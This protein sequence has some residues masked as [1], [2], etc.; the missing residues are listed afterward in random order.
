R[1]ERHQPD[2][3]AAVRRPH[4]RIPRAGRGRGATRPGGHPSVRRRPR[5]HPRPGG[6]GLN[7]RL[8]CGGA[9]TPAQYVRKER[10]PTTGIYL[11]DLLRAL[12]ITSTSWPFTRTVRRSAAIC[13]GVLRARASRHFFSCFSSSFAL[14]I[15]S[16]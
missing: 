7:H 14:T 12:V 15:S 8:L 2:G 13:C 1:Q 16:V 10:K 3:D 5:A 9:R 6:H 4:A 11:S